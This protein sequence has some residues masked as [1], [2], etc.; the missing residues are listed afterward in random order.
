MRNEDS[1]E[2]AHS[3][4]PA[5][6]SHD[7]GLERTRAVPE[8]GVEV[9]ARDDVAAALEGIH[10][11]APTED[12]VRSMERLMDDEGMVH[13]GTAR[14]PFSIAVNNAD[15]MATLMRGETT[16]GIVSET[17]Q[18]EAV[19]QGPSVRDELLSALRSATTREE[20]AQVLL[21]RAE[22][23]MVDLGWSKVP[24]NT[25]VEQVRN[26]H[27]T[28]IPDGAIE[29]M[30]YR[31]ETR[32]A[33]T[34]AEMVPPVSVDET[35]VE[36]PIVETAGTPEDHEIT[37]EVSEENRMRAESL[38]HNPT[39]LDDVAEAVRL[40]DDG[41]GH[42]MSDSGA[43][44][45]SIERT[46]EAILAAR[47]SIQ[48]RADAYAGN[49]SDSRVQYGVNEVFKREAAYMQP[50]P[51]AIGVQTPDDVQEQT[52]TTSSIGDAAE[53][54]STPVF[55]EAEMESVQPA[56]QP[57]QETPVAEEVI[58][59]AGSTAETVPGT[60]TTERELTREEK[61]GAF[62]EAITAIRVGQ[63]T[64]EQNFEQARDAIDEYDGARWSVPLDASSSIDKQ[65]ALVL[66]DRAQRGEDIS[67][68]NQYGPSLTH[69]ALYKKLIELNTAA[70]TGRY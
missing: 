20:I 5:F 37:N 33:D 52:D 45:L 66:V 28:N 17:Q 41:T 6:E 50:A 46:V 32:A 34:S 39:S 38:F 64:V 40:L 63:G 56:L 3:F 29:D 35:A 14:V 31:I 11:E 36:T 9:P 16:S 69:S 70:K 21:A 62:N 22:G 49:V 67:I 23:E 13:V 7:G 15:I 58:E 68:G 27:Y 12:Q 19:E 8:Q 30:V 57:R 42:F 53:P 55:P 43:G 51:E 65:D 1:F 60:S 59:P 26:G 10:S 25:L 44:K 24:I 54:V 18:V 47:D 4:A 48:G 61:L 2:P